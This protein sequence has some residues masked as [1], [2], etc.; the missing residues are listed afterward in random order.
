M[1]AK[2]FKQLIDECAVGHQGK[3]AGKKYVWLHDELVIFLDIQLSEFIPRAF[4][5]NVSY[6]LSAITGLPDIEA[7]EYLG[8]VFYRFSSGLSGEEY[9]DV[10]AIEE[11]QNEDDIR[12]ILERE[13][14]YFVKEVK[15][16]SDLGNVIKNRPNVR[17]FM[18]V[19]AE[20]HFGLTRPK[21][22]SFF[23][24]FNF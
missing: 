18:K 22:K 4:Y 19:I 13:F 2:R 3:K 12:I 5:I 20:E 17:P 21:K 14:A 24:R 10:F 1:E 6:F 11:I 15:T 7:F 9:S 16:S 8:D 23:D